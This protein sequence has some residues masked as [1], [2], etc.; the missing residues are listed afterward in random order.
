[1]HTKPG[2]AWTMVALLAATVI[3][4]A[5]ALPASAQ[6]PASSASLQSARSFLAITDRDDG[7]ASWEVAGKQFRD[8]ITKEK[9]AEALHR[10]RAPLGTVAS[11]TV[12]STQFMDAFP[13]AAR[14]GNYAILTFRTRFAAREAME[15]VTLEREADGLW[16]VIGYFIG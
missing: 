16:V 10:V 8:A 3:A 2:S 5:S 15:T 13:G 4:V 9:W 1:M 7:K 11:R 14:N 12:E 6:S